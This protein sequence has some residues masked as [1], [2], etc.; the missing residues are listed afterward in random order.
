MVFLFQLPWAGLA[1]TGSWGHPYCSTSVVAGPDNAWL[2]GG[3]KNSELR[4]LPQTLHALLVASSLLRA[5]PL[6]PSLH[7]PFALGFSCAAE[8]LFL[9]VFPLPDWTL[10]EWAL[11]KMKKS[12]QSH[13]AVYDMCLS[14]LLILIFAEKVA[15]TAPKL[16]SVPPNYPN[17]QWGREK[18]ICFSKSHSIFLFVNTGKD[19]IS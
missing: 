9:L 13:L 10:S 19:Y 11:W 5:R 3:V 17:N 4:V 16:P 18:A 1:V 15:R 2:G 12:R 6:Q 14:Q 8:F 7:L